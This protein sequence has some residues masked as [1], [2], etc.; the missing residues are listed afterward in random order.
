MEKEPE[1]DGSRHRYWSCDWSGDR[2]CL[3]QH[4]CWDSG[5][6]SHRRG[7]RGSVDSTAKNEEW[8]K[9]GLRDTGRVVMNC[10]ERKE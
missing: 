1:P 2:C 4:F 9:R 6:N 7:N 3:R 8:A 10:V 5:R